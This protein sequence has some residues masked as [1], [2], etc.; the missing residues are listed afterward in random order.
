ME[1]FHDPRNARGEDTA[2]HCGRKCIESKHGTDEEFFSHWPILSVPRIIEAIKFHNVF[3]HLWQHGRI[4]FASSHCRNLLLRRFP[5]FD[6]PN[7]P[8][9]LGAVGLY[10][11]KSVWMRF[12]VIDTVGIRSAHVGCTDCLQPDRGGGRG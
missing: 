9:V 12:L 3:F 8:R 4:R 1:R 7:S 6:G 2:S 5:G 10:T 11:V